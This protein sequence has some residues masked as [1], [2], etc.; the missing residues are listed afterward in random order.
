MSSLPSAVHSNIHMTFLDLVLEKKNFQICD[1][2]RVSI[3]E[4]RDHDPY[5]DKK[6]CQQHRQKP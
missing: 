1:K 6:M 3:E 4:S 2:L 5:A